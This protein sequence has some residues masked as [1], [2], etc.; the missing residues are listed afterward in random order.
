VPELPEVETVVRTLRPHL[1]GRRIV[2]VENCSAEA[3]AQTIS[4]LH[5][6]GKFI[7]L[8]CGAQHLLVHLGMTGKLL[9][10][11]PGQAPPLTPWT[12]ARLWLDEG[13]LL[14][15][16]IRRFGRLE[17]NGTIPHRGPDPLELNAEE[18]YALIH[19]RRAGIK[20]LLLNQDF[21]RG[22][23]NIYTDE[24]L[25]AAGIH[26]RALASNLSHAR[27]LGLHTA[28]QELLLAAIASGGSSISDYVDGD[29]RQGSF[30]EQHKVYG[31]AGQNC[32]ACSRPLLRMLVSQR[33][34]TY[35]RHCQRR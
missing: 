25:F 13:E 34:T 21:L 32:P 27:V 3:L 4:G 6:F 24:S 15:E 33:G 10:A 17:W 35:C 28:I 8:E 14:Y 30:Q 31:K 26:P 19:V 22:M 1:L 12:R 23:G 29:G 9:Y 5:R 20:A 16:D 18:F 2:A 7:V 11:A